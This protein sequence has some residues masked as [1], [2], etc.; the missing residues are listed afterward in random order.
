[1]SWAAAP[2]DAPDRLRAVVDDRQQP[3]CLGDREPSRVGVGQ[4]HLRGAV[5]PREQA[6]EQ[7]DLPAAGDQHPMSAHAVAQPDLA[8]PF[9][10]DAGLGGGVQQPFAQI[11]P[12]CVT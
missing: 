7:T 9:G 8:P 12:I 11:G 4:R 2:G 1:M 10:D 3:E 5:H 6:G